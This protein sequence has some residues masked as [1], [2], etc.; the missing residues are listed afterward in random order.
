[1]GPAASDPLARTTKYGI[2]VPSSDRAKCWATSKAASSKND[3]AVLIGDTE[4]PAGPTSPRSS[5]EG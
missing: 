3:G 5:V 4:A 1:M 2:D